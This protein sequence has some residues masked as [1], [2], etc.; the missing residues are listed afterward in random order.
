MGLGHPRSRARVLFPGPV[1]PTVIDAHCTCMQPP[2]LPR[3]DPVAVNSWSGGL[4]LGGLQRG[5]FGM[6]FNSCETKVSRCGTAFVFVRKYRS[7][8]SYSAKAISFSVPGRSTAGS[9]VARVWFPTCS[10]E[11]NTGLS[12]SGSTQGLFACC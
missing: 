1:S 7:I 3:L 9:Q 2:C 11:P 4:R 10:Q 12:F 5:F 8:V 6:I